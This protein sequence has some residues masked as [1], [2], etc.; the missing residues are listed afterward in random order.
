MNS[1]ISYISSFIKRAGSYIFLA[2]LVS[3]VFSFLASWIALQLLQPKPLGN[4]LYA[5]NF[6]VFL[7]P[8]VG[9]GL[10]QSYIRYGALLKSDEEKKQ[11]L[12]YIIR[13][14]I[15]GSV[16]MTLLVLVFSYLYSFQTTEIN[17]Y[18]YILSLVFVPIFL[19]ETIKVRARLE[20]QNKRFALLEITYNV[21]LIVAV[22]SLSFYGKTTGYAFSFVLTPLL[23]C[24]FFYQQLFANT[25]TN[26]KPHFVDF[27]FWKYGFFGG[28]SNVVTLLLFAI[29]ILLIG[30]ILKD[31]EQVTIYRY[32]TLIP[33][34]LL[35]LPRVF[36][37][38]DFVAFTEKIGNANYIRKYIKGYL[39]LFTLISLLICLTFYF[40]G[41]FFLALFDA[42]FTKYNQNFLILTVGICGILMLRGLYGNLLSSIGQVKVNF[43]ITSVAII[44]NYIAN[45]Q[46]IPLYG[47][48]G[49]AITTACLM[50]MTGVATL[51]CFHFL[52]KKFLLSLK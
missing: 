35:F 5:W 38:T 48:K 37:T 45:Q 2:T 46:L 10:H 20:H 7:T 34:S 40:S 44:V 22:F 16:I 32:L 12:N 27:E 1:L 28:L 11:L 47:I 41:I 4:V 24:L 52:Y 8:L 26:Q 6:I 31:P 9:L 3:R 51:V 36:I 50:W 17:N 13:N 25:T 19:F 15:I 14:G 21:I 18:L 33:F 23:T 39:L 42:S 29:D 43:Y 30:A 49:A